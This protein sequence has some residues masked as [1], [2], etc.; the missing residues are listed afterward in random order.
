M[1]VL[2]KDLGGL[3]ANLF[4]AVVIKAVSFGPF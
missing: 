2:F 4:H 1:M 3:L